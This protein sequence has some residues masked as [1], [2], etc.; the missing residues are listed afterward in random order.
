MSNLAT[1]YEEIGQL[2]QALPLF[3]QT[4]EL[5]KSQLGLDHPETL[6][7]MNGLAVCY[8]S[9]NMLDRSIPLLEQTLDLQIKKLGRSHIDSQF[10]VANLGVNYKDAGRVEEAIPLLEE[11]FASSKRFPQLAWVRAQLQSTYAL[12]KRVESFDKMASED[13]AAARDTYAPDSS[14]LAAALVSFGKEF[15]IL[16]DYLRARD[17]LLEGYTIRQKVA[18]DLWNTFNA[19]S[20]LGGSLLAR[21]QASLNQGD[22]EIDVEVK[23]TLL[24][25]AEPLL[26]AGYKGMK[27]R[28]S[29]IPPQA[30][31]AIPEA[32]DRLIELYTTLDKPEEVDRYR[33]LRRQYPEANGN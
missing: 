7:S 18:P 6:M 4:L 23:A 8:W 15:L 21:A 27:Q 16:G 12:G 10:S 1:V 25:E 26:L 5:R 11:A 14:E 20:L 24:A 2:D 30:A 29:T 22:N 32:L 17:L 19:Q 33:E 31:N 3:V 9:L 28:E 13:L